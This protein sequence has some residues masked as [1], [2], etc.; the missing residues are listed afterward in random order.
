MRDSVRLNRPWH[1]R[2]CGGF[3]NTSLGGPLVLSSEHEQTEQTEKEILYSLRYLRKL[4]E[5]SLLSLFAPVQISG[6]ARCVPWLLMIEKEFFGIDQGPD[7]VLVALLF[8]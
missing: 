6:C 3:S 5:E 8:V 7:D 1:Y 4:R 2:S